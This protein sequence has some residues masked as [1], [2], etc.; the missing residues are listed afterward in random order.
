MDQ[1]LQVAAVACAAVI[2]ILLGI[3]LARTPLTRWAEAFRF[4]RSLKRL[5]AVVDRWAMEM[6]PF[7]RRGGDGFVSDPLRHREHGPELD[8]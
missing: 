6:G 2:F 7:R 8:A 3:S 5:D 4:R 1:V